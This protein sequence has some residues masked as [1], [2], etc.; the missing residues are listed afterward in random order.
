MD[1]IIKSKTGLNDEIIIGNLKIK[2]LDKHYLLYNSIFDKN[3][4]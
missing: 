2:L 3:P 1:K 4:F